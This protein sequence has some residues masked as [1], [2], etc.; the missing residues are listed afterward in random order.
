MVYL[1]GIEHGLLGDPDRSLITVPT[2]ISSSLRAKSC[3]QIWNTAFMPNTLFFSKI[4]LFYKQF[5]PSGNYVV[6]LHPPVARPDIF[7][8]N[9]YYGVLK[10]GKFWYWTQ[11][12]HTETA[13]RP[14]TNNSHILCIL[15]WTEQVRGRSYWTH[16]GGPSGSVAN[17]L[18]SL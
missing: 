1:P 11:V 9:S 18:C 12:S 8:W 16:V 7:V 5:S 17:K 13:A 2:D 15:R 6:S 3:R 10:S 14:C 4:S